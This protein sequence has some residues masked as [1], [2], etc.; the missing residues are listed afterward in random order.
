MDRCST[1]RGDVVLSGLLRLTVGLLA[2]GVVLFDGGALL[3][4]RVQLDEAARVA[5]LSGARAWASHHS[6]AAV[7][8]A[9]GQRLATHPGMALEGVAVTG[10]RVAVTVARPAAVLLLDRVGP[11]SRVVQGRATSTSAAG[12]P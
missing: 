1:E 12:A 9:V 4:N 8:A 3:V 6:S 11:L 7:E 5:A 2:L 10:G